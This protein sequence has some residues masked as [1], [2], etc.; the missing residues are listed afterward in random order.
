MVKRQGDLWAE[1]VRAGSVLASVPVDADGDDEDEGGGEAEASDGQ[2]IK[3]IS[4][5]GHDYAAGK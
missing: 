3:H 4:S 2:L 5:D 1:G